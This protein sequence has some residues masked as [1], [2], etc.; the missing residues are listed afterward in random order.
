MKKYVL[1]GLFLMVV[2]LFGSRPSTCQGLQK[3]PEPNIRGQVMKALK[4]RTSIK[5]FIQRK[6]SGQVLSDLLWAAFGVADKKTGRRTAPSAFNVQEIDIYVLKADGVFLYD[7]MGNGLKQLNSN[8][9]RNSVASQNY[10]KSAPVH[11]VYVAD[12]DR[13]D[14]VYPESFGRNKE[15]WAMMH[16]G[17]ICQNVILYCSTKRMSAVVRSFGSRETLRKER[18]LS[19]A[20][21]IIISQAVG[22]SPR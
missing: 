22:Y 16:T 11:F 9:I 21:E 13:A 7:A 2:M 6:L 8:D 4:N 12:Y 3:L 10:A 15:K 18:H 19:D 5:G 14:T 1:P 17:F 20:Q